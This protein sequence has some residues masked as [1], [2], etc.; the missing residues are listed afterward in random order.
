MKL[1]QGPAALPRL[2]PLFYSEYQ[3]VKIVCTLPAQEWAGLSETVADNFNRLVRSTVVLVIAKLAKA[4]GWR[5]RGIN[6]GTLWTANYLS[7]L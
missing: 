1:V 7:N 2:Y 6:K 3:A 4:R 5:L